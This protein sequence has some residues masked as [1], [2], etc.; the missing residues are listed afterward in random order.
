MEEFH[1]YRQINIQK[2]KTVGATNSSAILGSIFKE[3]WENTHFK[4]SFISSSKNLEKESLYQQQIG[5]RNSI[6]SA[7]WNK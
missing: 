5:L 7:Q 4:D 1:V 6:G 2:R 3:A